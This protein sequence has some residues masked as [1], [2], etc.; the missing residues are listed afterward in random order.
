MNSTINDIPVHCVL[1]SGCA[2]T[3]ISRA[4]YTNRFGSLASLAGKPVVAIAFNGTTSRI[5][6]TYNTTISFSGC[7]DPLSIKIVEASNYEMILGV[8]SQSKYD[9]VI[10]RGKCTL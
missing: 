7:F 10:D 2:A 5:H 1:D 3:S 8:G 6:A 4:C 9:A